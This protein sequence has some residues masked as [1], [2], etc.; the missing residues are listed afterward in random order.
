MFFTTVSEIDFFIVIFF[1]RIFRIALSCPYVLLF[2]LKYE[3]INK[4]LLAKYYVLVLNFKGKF[5]AGKEGFMNFEFQC[6]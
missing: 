2:P 6:F 5:S 1:L 3:K 4:F